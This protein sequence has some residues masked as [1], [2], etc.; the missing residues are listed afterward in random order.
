MSITLSEIK[1]LIPITDGNPSDALLQQYIDIVTQEADLLLE[2]IFA[3]PFSVVTEAD[4]INYGTANS[5]GSN[6]IAIRAW[7]PTGLTIKR[8]T[9]D[10][11]QL[12]ALE[13]D[14]LTSGDDY[15]F[16]YG[17]KGNKIPGLNLPVT[18][19]KLLC[20]RLMPWEVLRVYGTYGWQEGYPAVV[21]QALTNVIVQ[22]ASYATQL[23]LN[24]GVSGL[25]RIKSMTTEIEIS[26][27]LAGAIRNQARS[28]LNDPVFYGIINTYLITTD[29]NLSIL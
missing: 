26:E 13:E 7:Q 6:I 27:E 20:T 25:T 3:S 18:N 21:K 19:I 16:W 29:N 17:W 28:L 4:C 2:N 15:V 10:N 23:A 22:L 9:K 5:K 24:G 11:S 12:E 14:V 8:T 1:A